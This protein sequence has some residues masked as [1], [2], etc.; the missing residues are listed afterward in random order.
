[1]LQAVMGAI[2]RRE[3]RMGRALVGQG[4]GEPVPVCRTAPILASLP[5]PSPTRITEA[6]WASAKAFASAKASTASLMIALPPRAIAAA[7]SSSFVL[8]TASSDLNRS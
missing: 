4:D 7:G 8:A 6:R 2:E 3:E 1:M 5:S